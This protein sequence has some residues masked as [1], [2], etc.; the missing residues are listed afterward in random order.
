LTFDSSLSLHLTILQV[1]YFAM[2]SRSEILQEHYGVQ[3]YKEANAI[4]VQI[5][6]NSQIPD[7]SQ[8]TKLKLPY[9]ASS[10]PDIPSLEEIKEAMKKNWLSKK[11]GMFSVWRVGQ[12]VVKMGSD[13]MIVQV[14]GLE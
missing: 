14:S 13:E 11:G 9:E 3:T 1:F 10:H 4:A 8:R 2:R 6:R 12:C 5:F 7:L